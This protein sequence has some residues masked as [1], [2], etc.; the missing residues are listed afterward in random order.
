MTP[1]CSAL[2]RLLRREEVLVLE[3]ERYFRNGDESR[4]FKEFADGHERLDLYAR[5]FGRFEVFGRGGRLDLGKNG[6]AIAILKRLL[7]EKLHA[8]SQ[9]LL[10]DQLWPYSSPR[11]ARWSLN[12]SVYA[13]RRLMDSWA[14]VP[15]GCIVLER[16]SYRLS[17]EL[18]VA[19]DVEEFDGRRERGRW[20][21]RSGEKEGAIREY[22]EASGLYRGDYL[23]EDL[24]DDWTMIERER[25][26]GAYVD[27][28]ESLARHYAD[29]GELQ[30]SIE[31][32]YRLL[33]RE[34]CHEESYRL[35]MRCYARRGLLK[36]ALHQYRVCEQVLRAMYGASPERESRE[37]YE[38]LQRGEVL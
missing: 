28:M 16:G 5:L 1:S 11:K 30:K 13:L 7:A 22:E 2:G 6:R 19:S 35:L 27:A 34:P 38:R 20:F 9:D 3:A 8:A 4:G 32:C 25:L 37:L 12:S 23:A 18:R 10:M 26:A 33:A 31:A 17:P 14:G 15:A 24:Y 36:Q 21:K 29:S